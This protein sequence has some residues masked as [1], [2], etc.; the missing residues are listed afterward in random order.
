MEY[1]TSNSFRFMGTGFTE[2]EFKEGAD[3]A[4]Y[5]EEAEQLKA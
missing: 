1:N 4:W 5:V 3:L 2:A